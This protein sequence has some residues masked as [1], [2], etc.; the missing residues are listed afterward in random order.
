MKLQEI[1]PRAIAKQMLW[2]TTILNLMNK[3]HVQTVYDPISVS[4]ITRLIKL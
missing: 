1:M 4:A 3:E 2:Q